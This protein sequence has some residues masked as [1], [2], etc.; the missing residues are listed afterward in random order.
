MSVNEEKN[1]EPKILVFACQY[2]TYAGADLA[3]LSRLQYP[4]TTRV[5]RVPCSGRVN[6]QFV[7]RAF[8]KGV[9]GVLVAGCH[10]GDC[11]FST[12]NYF[13]RRRFL[14]MKRLMDFVG[15]DSRRFHVRW[16]SGSEGPKF[17]QVVTE[18]TEEIRQ[19]G[20]NQKWRESHE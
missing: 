17:Q 18:I 20:P 2:C 4:P 16:I 1:W 11:H 19:L 8:Q 3:G 13:A 15:I 9:D 7:I 6:P 14:L 10:P 12:G 5:L